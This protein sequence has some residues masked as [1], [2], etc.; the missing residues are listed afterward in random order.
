MHL[1]AQLSWYPVILF[2][3]TCQVTLGIGGASVGFV[4][5]PWLGR[6]LFRCLPMGFVAGGVGRGSAA[7]NCS[8]QPAL[9][10]PAPLAARALAAVAVNASVPATPPHVLAGF[11]IAHPPASSSDPRAIPW[12]FNHLSLLD[13]FVLRCMY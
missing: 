12:D 9:A 7:T 10:S 13:G 2:L 1:F 8:P 4:V 3:D 5:P 6:W 11:S